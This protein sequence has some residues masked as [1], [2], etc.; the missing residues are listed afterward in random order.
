MKKVIRF[1]HSIFSEDGVTVFNTTAPDT[2]TS[3]VA[4]V[5]AISDNT[6]LGVA[7]GT[8]KVEKLCHNPIENF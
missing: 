4:S 1:N 3:W 2:I 7:P 6:G 5:F 8:Q